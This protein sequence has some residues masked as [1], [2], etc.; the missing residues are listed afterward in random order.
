M[1]IL[2]ILLLLCNNVSAQYVDPN[3]TISSPK[4]NISPVDGLYSVDSVTIGIKNKGIST[5]KINWTLG[6]NL[7]F[8]TLT[9]K[10]D[11][12][13]PTVIG[14]NPEYR[15]ITAGKEPNQVYLISG[16]PGSGYAYY[17]M[18][19]NGV[20]LVPLVHYTAVGEKVTFIVSIVQGDKIFYRKLR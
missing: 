20:H 15:D 17:D 12:I 8:D 3:G 9:G 16:L 10:L 19:K 6:P 2:I 7:K 14:G 11:A 18:Y 5:S 13:I 4:W 1:K